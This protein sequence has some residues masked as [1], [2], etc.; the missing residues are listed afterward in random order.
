MFVSVHGWWICN[1]R[2]RDEKKKKQE[3]KTEK[4]KINT[5]LCLI[6]FVSSQGGIENETYIEKERKANR[7]RK[8]N[9]PNHK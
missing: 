6:K 3:K 8:T 1:V 7:E 2:T 4:K 9:D 5:N